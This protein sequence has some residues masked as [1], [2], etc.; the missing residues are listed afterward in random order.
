MSV[1]NSSVIAPPQM[2]V[3]PV[4]YR[5]RTYHHWRHHRYYAWNPG[6]A[7]AGTALGLLSLPFWAATGG[8]GWC[9]PYYDSTCYGGYGW[10]YTYSYYGGPYYRH[11]GYWHGGRWGGQRFAA[12]GG[13]IRT[14]RSVGFHGGGFH[15]G[16]HR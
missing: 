10:P 11:Y 14:G 16:G 15:G 5:Y 1:A 6:A 8:Y 7:V 4:Y 9:E 3:E 12:Y 13:G 2:Q